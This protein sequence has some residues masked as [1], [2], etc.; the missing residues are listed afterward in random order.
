MGHLEIQIVGDPD[1]EGIAGEVNVV[2]TQKRVGSATATAIRDAVVDRMGA[3]CAPEEVVS[4]E[5]LGLDDYPRTAV[6]EARKHKLAALVKAYRR[7][8]SDGGNPTPSDSANNESHAHSPTDAEGRISS[9]LDRLVRIWSQIIGIYDE[10]KRLS[11]DTDVKTLPVDSFGLLPFDKT[12]EDGKL[13]GGNAQSGEP[14]PRV[15]QRLKTWWFILTESP[16]LFHLTKE[17]ATEA[18]RGCGLSWKDV[19]AVMRAS[20][21]SAVSFRLRRSLHRAILNNL[22]MVSFIVADAK[23]L[24]RN[25]ALHVQVDFDEAFLDEAFLD[26]FVL[27]D[28]GMVKTD[29]DM[30]DSPSSNTTLDVTTL[31]TRISKAF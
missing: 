23:K 31:C 18:V 21:L 9:T 10:Q 7:L 5:D 11:P 6:G 16:S 19:R 12:S 13:V 15:L 28:A 4:L 17:V 2:V 14:L 26:K 22:M 24:V 20:D 8:R 1:D 25:L 3:A 27:A 29:S 30:V